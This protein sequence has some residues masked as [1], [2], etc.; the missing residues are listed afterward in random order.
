MAK[1]GK[2]KDSLKLR[3]KVVEEMNRTLK[4]EDGEL[5]EAINQTQC[6]TQTEEIYRTATILDG[7]N[8]KDR[9]VTRALS[10]EEMAAAEQAAKQARG[11]RRAPSTQVDREETREFLPAGQTPENAGQGGFQGHL[12]TVI[13]FV[14]NK[15]NPPEA[16]SSTDLSLKHEEKGDS[17]PELNLDE[18][19]ED[20]TLPQLDARYEILRKFAKGGQGIVSK[21]RDKALRRIV[22]VKSLRPELLNREAIRKNFL[23][24]ALITAQLD[25]PSVVP[26]YAL[27]QDD[28]EGLHLSMKLLQGE[29]LHEHLDKVEQGYARGAS[30]QWR[31]NTRVK[32]DLA[33]FL[34]VCEAIS[35]AHNRH[36]IH[37]DLKPDNIMLGKY[38][39]VFVMDWGLARV[40][41]KNQDAPPPGGKI[42]LDGTPRFIPPEAYAGVPRDERADIFALG[43]ILFEIVTLRPGYDGRSIKEVV[44]QVRSGDRTPV[45]HRFGYRIK[46]DLVAIID[47]ACAYDPSDRYQ[48]VQELTDDLQRYLNDEETEVLPDSFPRWFLRYLRHHVTLV[49]ILALASWISALLVSLRS[50]QK[51]EKHN[52]AS[53]RLTQDAMKS[54][55]QENLER[56]YE[57][58]VNSVTDANCSRAQRLGNRLQSYSDHLQFIAL[59]ASAC[60]RHPP[61]GEVRTALPVYGV[62]EFPQGRSVYSAALERNIGLDFCTYFQPPGQDPAAARREVEQLKPLTPLLRHLVLASEQPSLALPPDLSYQVLGKKCADLGMPIL[63]AYIA[64]EA[65]HLQLCYPGHNAYASTYDNHDRPW[66]R[67]AREN[68]AARNYSPTLGLPYLDDTTGFLVLNCTV[69]IIGKEGTFLGACSLKMK[70]E[71]FEHFIRES[72]EAQDYE[73]EYWLVTR[74]GRKLLHRQWNPLLPEDRLNPVPA[75]VP[76]EHISPPI[77]TICQDLFPPGKANFF[78]SREFLENGYRVTYHYASL[79]P[80]GLRLILKTSRERLFQR[81]EPLSPVAADFPQSQAFPSLSQARP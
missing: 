17:L 50:I 80:Q 77:H 57:A 12:K 38:G 66:Y 20:P 63:Q 14:Q 33:I 70:I 75:A 32:G 48:T 15:L 55:Q 45:E 54:L 56:Q 76:E 47:K 68:A 28:Q 65:S 4:E 44:R 31:F 49:I 74:K 16:D 26:I 39:E 79:E 61:V 23:Q 41:H 7:E 71:A 72:E 2:E 52:L 59:Q 37:C 25:H 1:T 19:T 78:G 8:R 29:T 11:R 60:L 64:T 21:A 18:L 51:Q 35:Y 6:L 27:M 3:E 69:P 24:E 53:I 62:P 73:L 13:L 58:M 67:Q 22:A 43:L 46:K 36:I 42:K 9:D 81:I 30:S 40:I 10:P 34:K 5:Q